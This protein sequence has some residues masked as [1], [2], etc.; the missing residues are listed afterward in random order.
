MLSNR[1]ISSYDMHSVGEGVCVCVEND[2]K[3]NLKSAEISFPL[4]ESWT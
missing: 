2:R 3:F 4:I 1:I